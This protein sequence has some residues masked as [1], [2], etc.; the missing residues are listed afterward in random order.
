MML[1]KPV[2]VGIIG[3]GSVSGSYISRL[4]KFPVLEIHACADLELY[5]A[6]AKAEQYKIPRACTVEELLKDKKIQVV[7]NLTPP[8]LHARINLAILQAGKHLYSEKPLTL[9]REEAKKLLTEAFQQKLLIGCAPDTFFGGGIQ[10]CRKLIDEGAIGV[11]IAATAFMGSAGHEH[12]HPAPEIFYQPGGGP[13]FDMG[14]Y[15]LTTLVYLIGRIARVSGSARAS[16]PERTITTESRRGATIPVQVSTHYSGV[17]DFANGAI[18]TIIQSFDLPSHHLPHIEIYGTEGTLSVPDPYTYDGP[19]KIRSH[20]SND[21]R[22]VPLT[23]S[24][25]VGRGVGLAD[26]AYA[27]THGRPHR[28]HG[29]L[30]YH[31]L[32]VMLAFEESSHSGHHILIETPCE[33]PTPLPTDLAPGEL[34]F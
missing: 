21:W 2:K 6:E 22:E 24:R 10:T 17:I 13:M 9:S 20:R 26:L 7:L 19:V 16:Y 29:Q 14:P 8:K 23:H 3:C 28:A 4:K 25:D 12:W 11:P 18:G 30:A 31:I 1:L 5:R 33:R 27:I 32:D 34:D 15:Y